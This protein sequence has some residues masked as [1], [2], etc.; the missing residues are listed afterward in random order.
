MNL[1]SR[2]VSELPVILYVH[3]R[4]LNVSC[5]IFFGQTLF[6]REIHDCTYVWKKKRRVT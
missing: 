4:I 2:Q 1:R 5:L 3:V 6:F